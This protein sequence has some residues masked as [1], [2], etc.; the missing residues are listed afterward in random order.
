MSPTIS[1]IGTTA[2]SWAISTATA[3]RPV[4][5][6]RSPMSSIILMATAVED[7]AAAKA[8]STANGH[9]QPISAA[10]APGD[11][12]ESRDLAERDQ[13]RRAPDFH[14]G[15]DRQLE[16][17]H[18]QQHEHAEIGEQADLVLVCDEAGGGRAEQDAGE[19]VADHG[20]L[21]QARHQ[22]AAQKRREPDDRDPGQVR[23][24]RHGAIL[25]RRWWQDRGGVAGLV[26]RTA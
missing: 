22:H 16:A 26:P 1:I 15:G 23:V 13:E 17:D 21:A 25:A 7:S 11:D 10:Y 2:R 8:S 4:S 12:E 6:S 20:G 5:V 24:S 18:E 14:E 19:D 3:M 9:G